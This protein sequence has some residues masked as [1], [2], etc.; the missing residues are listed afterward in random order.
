MYHLYK[1]EMDGMG[2]TKQIKHIRIFILNPE[3]QVEPRE[4]I[5]E[6]NSP[7]EETGLV[8]SSKDKFFLCFPC[9]S[10]PFSVFPFPLLQL[11]T[12]PS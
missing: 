9:L 8:Y 7:K 11:L 12:D 4:Q 1:D 2:K 5:Q 10:L 6:L 3:L